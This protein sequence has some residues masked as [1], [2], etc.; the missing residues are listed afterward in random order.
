MCAAETYSTLTPP[1]SI[2]ATDID[3]NVLAIAREGI[4]NNDRIRSLSQ[5]RL[6]QFFYRGKKSKEGKVKVVPEIQ[7]LVKFTSLNLTDQQWPSIKGPFD[8]VFCRNVMIYFDKPTQ[9]KILTKLVGTM[10]SHGLYFAG[11]SE[12]FLNAS[13]IVVPVGKTVYKKA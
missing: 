10:S 6:K 8:I 9:L 2:I 7:N 1:V 4:Y 13:N 3:S 12:S 5:N 11:H